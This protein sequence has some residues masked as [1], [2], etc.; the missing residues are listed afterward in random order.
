M[1]K[2]QKTILIVDDDAE[3]RDFLAILID[4]KD[5]IVRFAGTIAEARNVIE[6]E[7]I[8]VIFLDLLLP[9]GNGLV[10][11]DNWEESHSGEHPCMIIMSAFGNW[12][13]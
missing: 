2:S 7:P 4:S 3:I 6:R 9:D 11:L 13:N 8:H 10:L 5:T 1:S 12:E